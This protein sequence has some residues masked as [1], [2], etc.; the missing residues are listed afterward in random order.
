MRQTCEVAQLLPSKLSH[1]PFQIDPYFTIVVFIVVFFV[2][3]VV[4]SELK[5]SKATKLTTKSIGR[6]FFKQVVVVG[7]NHALSSDWVTN[8]ESVGI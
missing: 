6:G 3:I 7:D 8:L 5:N 1:L 4:A 2:V